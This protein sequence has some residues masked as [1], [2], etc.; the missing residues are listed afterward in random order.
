MGCGC[1]KRLRKGL[2]LL[3]WQRD[4]HWWVDPDTGERIADASIETHHTRIAISLLTSKLHQ[5][6]L[7]TSSRRMG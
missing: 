7:P 6:T 2:E 3:N 5:R 1:A 4:G